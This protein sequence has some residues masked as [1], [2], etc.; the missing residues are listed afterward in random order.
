MAKQLK[1]NGGENPAA[2]HNSVAHA[3][4][5][6]KLDAALRP[7][8]ADKEKIAA[9]MK[10]LRKQFKADTGITLGDFDA[11]RRLALLDDDDARQKTIDN[12][13]R[14][15]NALSPGE[16]LDWTTAVEETGAEADAKAEATG[17]PAPAGA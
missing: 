12:M 7:L 14:C 2:G 17:E 1:P 11:A 8:E 9:D 10:K 16:T 13:V 6:K 15:Y 4:A 3:P 5:I